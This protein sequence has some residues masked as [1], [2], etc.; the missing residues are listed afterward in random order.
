MVTGSII[1]VLVYNLLTISSKELKYFIHAPTNWKNSELIIT[2][3]VLRIISLLFH[4]YRKKIF[5][6]HK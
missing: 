1:E 2:F 6:H 4:N 5:T 3:F